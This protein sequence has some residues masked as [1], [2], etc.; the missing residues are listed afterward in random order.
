MNVNEVLANRASE[1][2]GGGR[3]S[4]RLVHPNDDEAERGSDGGGPRGTVSKLSAAAVLA[5]QISAWALSS[6]IS[7]H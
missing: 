6:S 4:E 2:L 5:H 7:D 3:G 1:I